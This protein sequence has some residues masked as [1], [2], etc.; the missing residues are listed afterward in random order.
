MLCGG[1]VLRLLIL[2]CCCRCCFDVF[3]A[4]SF[5]FVT[6][7]RF[8]RHAAAASHLRRH[9]LR[10]RLRFR[11]LR[12]FDTPLRLPYADCSATIREL[13]IDIVARSYD[14]PAE[15]A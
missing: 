10:C 14:A 4:A 8:I 3:F 15:R 7:F 1:G 6:D 13:L 2:L 12:T 9:A 5:H 11:C